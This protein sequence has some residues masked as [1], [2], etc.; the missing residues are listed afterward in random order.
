MPVQKQT[1]AGQRTRFKVRGTHAPLQPLA[2]CRH[3]AAHVEWSHGG[4]IGFVQ[5][6]L[7]QQLPFRS[8]FREEDI[9]SRAGRATAPIR[10][11]LTSRSLGT[12]FSQAFV[13][14]GDFNGHVGLGVKCAK[15]VAT[16]IRGAI[17]AAKLNVVPVRRGYWGNKIGKP[18][19]VPTKIT[20]KV[21]SSSKQPKINAGAFALA[22]LQASPPRQ[23][24][25][26]S[27]R[28]VLL[29]DLPLPFPA[30]GRLRL[31]PP[32][33]GA[34]GCR[35]RRCLHP[36]EGAR[37]GRHPGR[38][39]RVPG[40]CPTVPPPPYTPLFGPGAGVGQWLLLA[41]P[42]NCCCVE[43]C[44]RGCGRRPKADVPACCRLASSPPFSAARRPC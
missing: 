41:M 11:V 19:T 14:V 33:P 10:R 17:I 2:S 44:A 13:V 18:H 4:S 32:R 25:P 29:A 37:H 5:L 31:P 8:A 27:R 24:T 16:A 20:G 21:S 43:L 36:E 35:H 42:R 26:R 6:S 30:T 12:R 15:E 34:Q 23:V 28:I 38:V 3:D 7:Q 39:H 40:S 22:A 9:L 1:R